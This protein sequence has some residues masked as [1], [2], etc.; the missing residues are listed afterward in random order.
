MTCMTYECE[1]DR[2]SI[3]PDGECHEYDDTLESKYEQLQ[4]EATECSKSV[5]QMNGKIQ[6][7]MLQLQEEISQKERLTNDLLSEKEMSA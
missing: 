1:D 6:E 3:G 4:G 7:L 5:G 2:D